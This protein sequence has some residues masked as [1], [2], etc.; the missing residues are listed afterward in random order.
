M[1]T[2]EG[3]SHSITEIAALVQPDRVHRAVYTDPDIFEIELRRLWG[4]A[5]IYVGHESQIPSTGDYT[6]SE[7][8]RQ[9]VILVRH[10]DGSAR[11]LFN[12][13]AHKGAEVVTERSGNAKYFYCNYHGW[14]YR[15]D[16]TLANL[17]LR[18]GYEGTCFSMTDP[19]FSL[20]P[21]PRVESYRGF[22]FASLA[23]SGPD[24]RTFL[25]PSLEAFD[26][27]CDRS[28]EGEVEVMGTCARTIQHSNWKFFMENQLDV[29]HAGIVH[30]SSAQA[31]RK[32]AAEHFEKGAKQPFGLVMLQAQVA[33]DP[34][35]FW[36][37]LLSNNFRYGHSNFL[38]YQPSRGDD[39]VTL[40][41]EEQLRKKVGK[42]KAEKFL[43]R[44][45]HHTVVYPCL[46]VQSSFQQLRVVKPL[47]VDRTLMEIWHFRLKGVSKAFTARNL[48]YANIVNTPG[49]IIS[50]DDY[51]TW[52][53]CHE[54]LKSQ[55]GDWVSIHRNAGGDLIDGDIV[56]S[57][58]GSS[59]VFQRN[60]YAAW[61]AYMT[62]E[63]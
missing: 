29:I 21:V 14:T 46:S 58:V 10:S 49:T 63:V 20:Q 15:T 53:R 26:D 25:G 32:V 52:W 5:W 33:P 16:G 24:L 37:K 30:L 59:E 48:T 40:E 1:T 12:R 18:K 11:V 42:E 35:S 27:M 47:A 22:V 39:P 51:E 9:P 38:G 36:E 4:T 44:N 2:T 62:E 3:T 8:A 17:P 60:Q 55:G 7:I 54:G 56:R 41:Y 57:R 61:Q 43:S 23:A 45:F 13:C 50:C 19:Q 6:T 34:D 31:A 28:P